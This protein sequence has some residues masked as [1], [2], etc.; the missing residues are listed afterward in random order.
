M[1]MGTWGSIM[2]QRSAKEVGELEFQ[3]LIKNS[4]SCQFSL[5]IQKH[6]T[7]ALVSLMLDDVRCRHNF[8]GIEEL[9][10]EF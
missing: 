4:N 10:M 2:Y 6:S 1:G 9:K 8:V 3:L 5:D 7:S